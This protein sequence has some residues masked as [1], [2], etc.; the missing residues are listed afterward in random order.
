MFKVNKLKVLYKTKNKCRVF[1]VLFPIK[2][3]ML[4][5]E[6]FSDRK[7]FTSAESSHNETNPEWV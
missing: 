7:R 3:K 6:N 1:N 5:V 2:K 4:P